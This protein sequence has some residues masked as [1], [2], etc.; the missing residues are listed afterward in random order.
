MASPEGGQAWVR[1]PGLSTAVNVDRKAQRREEETTKGEI[2]ETISAYFRS[3]FADPP[4][5]VKGIK[6]YYSLSGL[7]K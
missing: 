1:V 5:S 2:P 6:K 7:F 4:L 3:K